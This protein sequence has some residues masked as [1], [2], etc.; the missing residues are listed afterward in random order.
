MLCIQKC[1]IKSPRV[2][3]LHWNVFMQRIE[4]KMVWA[5][6]AFPFSSAVNRIFYAEILQALLFC[7]VNLDGIPLPEV[8]ISI[9]DCLNRRIHQNQGH[10]FR[11]FIIVCYRVIY[12]MDKIYAKNLFLEI[13]KKVVAVVVIVFFLFFHSLHVD[14]VTVFFYFFF[15]FSS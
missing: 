3:F 2:D 12:I 13:L 9:I 8:K 4:S 6:Q 7:R 5:I 15:L 10:Y 14:V 11:M 1:L